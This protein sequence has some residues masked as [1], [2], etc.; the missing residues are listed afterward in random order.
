MLSESSSCLWF[1]LLTTV[2][3]AWV[4]IDLGL[5]LIATAA[6]GVVW[7]AFRLAIASTRSADGTGS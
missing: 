6:T 2:A 5:A 4:I 1:P 7:A 3:A